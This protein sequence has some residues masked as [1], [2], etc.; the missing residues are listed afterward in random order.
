VKETMSRNTLAKVLVIALLIFT[1]LMTP[2]TNRDWIKVGILIFGMVNV[3]LDLPGTLVIR[4]MAIAATFATLLDRELFALMLV[5]AW[6]VWPPAL[7]VSWALGRESRLAPDG[8]QAERGAA[9]LKART[10]V[11]GLIGAVAVASLAY[12]IIVAGGL[13]Q[14]AAL[15]V[16]VPALL[17]IVVVFAISPRSATGVACKA[18][19]VGLLIS[20]LFLGEGFLCILMSAPV[21]Y[22]VAVSIARIIEVYRSRHQRS[23]TML[24][25]CLLLL[26]W[27][28]VDRHESVSETKIVEASSQAVEHALLDSPRFDRKL[29]P[30][31]R[32]GFPRPIATRIDETPDKKV[33]AIRFRGGE[34]RING[35]EPREGDLLLE[36]EEARPGLVRWRAVSDTSHMTHFLWWRESIV[37][38][39]PVTA[40]TTRVTWTLRYERGLD[41]AWYFGPW[42][43]YAA[44]LAAGY[45]IDSVATP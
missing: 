9:S 20:V 23:A 8:E 43:R 40:N 19:T 11:A 12:R 6:L 30:Y 32:A 38:W 16:G 10:T 33:W 35:T 29:P 45:L 3:L 42:E 15:F 26:A 4:A 31:L 7:M 13:Q 27:I 24:M 5:L 39:E 17:A 2:P 34:T 1:V 37:T 36:M 14:T 21:F 28:P 41:P 25:S 44:G 22:G 18:V